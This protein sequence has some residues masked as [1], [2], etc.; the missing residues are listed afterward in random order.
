MITFMVVVAAARSC[1]CSK[2]LPLPRWMLP[3]PEMDHNLRGW[4]ED[5]I[6][7]KLKKIDVRTAGVEISRFRVEIG[8]V[9]TAFSTRAVYWKLL[10]IIP[11]DLINFLFRTWS[12]SWW[13]W[14]LLLEVAAARSCCRFR[15]GC[16]QSQKWTIPSC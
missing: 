6:Q 3:I 9:R 15:D 12:H 13:W 10:C 16:F 11:K 7:G 4:K 5:Q 14:L 1:C 8:L 2:L